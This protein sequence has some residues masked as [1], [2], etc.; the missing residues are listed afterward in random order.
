MKASSTETPGLEGQFERRIQALFFYAR[1][2][3][4]STRLGKREVANAYYGLLMNSINIAAKLASEMEL[5]KMDKLSPIL[6]V[7]T[8]D[9]LY[10]LSKTAIL[11]AL[12]VLY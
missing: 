10:N 3:N 11:S 1:C 6:V 5:K 8:K 7:Q 9:R 4:K 2:C 12:T